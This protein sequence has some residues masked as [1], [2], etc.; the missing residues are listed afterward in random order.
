M[1][2]QP[3]STEPA[4]VPGTAPGT[5]VVHF[6]DPAI[7]A[8]FTAVSPR[9]VK[10]AGKG[11]ISF[12]GAC[13]VLRGRRPRPFWVAARSEMRIPLADIVNVIREESV[14]QCHVRLAGETKVLRLWATDGQSAESLVQALPAQR[15][16][17][18]EQRLAEHRS[19]DAAL[20]GMVTR[21]V[22]TPALVI[23]NCVIFACTVYAGAGLIESNGA[24]LV[25]WGTNYGPRTLDGESWRLFTS[26]FLHFGLLH[27]A[28]NM[29]AL[30][31]VGKLTERLYGS[32]YFLVLY[33]FA[34]IAGSLLSL[35]WHPNT[36]SA[37]ASGAIFGVLGALL[38]FMVNPRTRIPGSI[39]AVHLKSA[40]VFIL[41]NLFNGFAHAGIDNAAHIGGLA[42]G[43]AMGWVLA[44]P[45]GAEERKD[46]LP[47]LAVAV[48]IGVCAIT[49]LSWPLFHPGPTG[50]AE[51]RF[52]HQ[53]QLY[54]QDEERV[55]AAQNRLN[56]LEVAKKITDRD[57]GLRTATEII[58]EWKTAED[59]ISSVELP[60]DSHQFA[61][62]VALIDYLDQKRAA[63]ELLSSGARDNNAAK[64]ER[65]KQASIANEAKVGR[66]Q[67]LIRQVY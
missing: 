67:A 9:S 23:I 66:I 1:D 15:T 41:Y 65:G 31:S 49:V 56:Q 50:V 21:P 51:R 8:R 2:L 37:G 18:F 40:A 33:I 10:F 44:R 46:P 20:A 34:G 4:V 36:N 52:M 45:V 14:V 60:P 54:A 35:Y 53:F 11:T 32:A 59:R 3:I 47:R 29:W 57:W 39:A 63:L 22:V 28:L 42:G 7:L 43:F 58:P 27:V 17:D 30:W 26:M 24:F 38:A 61:L 5:F 25:Q 64:L 62:R 13:A 19:F 16:A 48:A 55:V 6:T 12:D